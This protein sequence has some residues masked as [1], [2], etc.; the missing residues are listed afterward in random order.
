MKVVLIRHPAPLIEAGMCYGRL[1]VALHPAAD[2]VVA[3]LVAHPVLR[4]IGLVWSSPAIRCRTVADSIA[5]H[6]GADMMPD[7]RLL[8][9]DFGA[10][11]GRAWDTLD[12][13]ELDRWAGDP[14]SFAPPGGE[15]GAGIVA[16]VRAFHAR[17]ACDGRD[18]AVVSHGGP[19]KILGA[20]LDARPIDLLEAAPALGSVRVVSV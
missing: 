10:W 8:E 4:N 13:A 7:E 9:L 3:A 19:L 20:L 16:R 6:T 2:Q 18:C 17:L 11:E 5:R 15:S 1:D 12:Q 14:W